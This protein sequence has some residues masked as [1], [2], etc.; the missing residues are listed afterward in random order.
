MRI[1]WLWTK[2]TE[3]HSGFMIDLYL[4]DSAFTA[5]KRDAKVYTRYVKGVPFFNRR[6]KMGCKMVSGLKNYWV[7]H[8]PLLLSPT[9]GDREATIACM[10]PPGESRFST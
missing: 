7:H 5:L 3:N 2:K 10:L 1:L 8:P 4:K 9:P 6:S